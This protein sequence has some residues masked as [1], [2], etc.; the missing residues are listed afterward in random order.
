MSLDVYQ[1][2]PP[3]SGSTLKQIKTTKHPRLNRHLTVSNYYSQRS[4]F[5]ILPKEYGHILRFQ[6]LDAAVVKR[7][8]FQVDSY[9]I[10]D[11]H[12]RQLLLWKFQL[13]LIEVKTLPCKLLQS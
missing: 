12:L 4:T 6:N 7:R 9:S 1:N 3:G 2:F 8:V 5:T 10:F 13:P 11:G